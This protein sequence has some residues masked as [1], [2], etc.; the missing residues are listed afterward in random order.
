MRGRTLSVPA[1]FA[2]FLREERKSVAF[3]EYR[4]AADGSARIGTM[5]GR[6][7]K[8]AFQL[9]PWHVGALNACGAFNFAAAPWK[10]ARKLAARPTGSA[11]HSWKIEAFRPCCFLD[12]GGQELRQM[13]LGIFSALAPLRFVGTTPPHAHLRPTSKATAGSARTRQGTLGSLDPPSAAAPSDE[14]T[15]HLE[16]QAQAATTAAQRRQFELRPHQKRTPA[17]C[18]VTTTAQTASP[19]RGRNWVQAQ[20]AR[21]KPR[22]P[23]RCA[24]TP[25]FVRT[26][27]APQRSSADHRR[28]DRAASARQQ[29][30]AASGRRRKPRPPRRSAVNSNFALTRNAPQ[31]SSADHRRADRA[32]QTRQ[33]LGAGSACLS[34]LCGRGGRGGGSPG[35]SGG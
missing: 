5:R 12:S 6:T 4:G 22:P 3:C 9:F 15:F 18:A 19:K 30:R 17:V 25:N 10:F 29:L 33:Q 20:P 11:R 32:A 13:L 34:L 28:A 31:R 16:T 24:A 27:N 8:L 2:L 35:R 26:R 14:P 1:V 21:R 23:R 7:L